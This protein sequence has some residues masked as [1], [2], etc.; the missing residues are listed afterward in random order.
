[1]TENQMK[2]RMKAINKQIEALREEKQKYEN[3]FSDKKRSETLNNYINFE[4]KYFSSKNLPHNEHRYVKAFKILKVLSVPNERHAEC[5]VLID[6]Y[7]GQCWN[8]FGIQRM[9]LPLW[10]FNT[11]RLMNKESEPKMI[12]MYR[13]ISEKEFI[14]IS[15]SI[16]KEIKGIIE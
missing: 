2:E 3:Y 13:E 5:I 15:E 8:E 4:G 1:M 7:R 12:D 14:K 10:V 6:G 16:I 11:L 9:T